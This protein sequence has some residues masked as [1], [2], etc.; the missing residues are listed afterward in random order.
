M[1][2]REVGDKMG[3]RHL[4]RDEI[5]QQCKHIAREKRMANRTPWTAMSIMC[6]YVIMKQ[7]GFKGQ[8]IA[9]ITGR[10]NEMEAQYDNGDID[11]KQISDKLFEKAEWTIEYERYTEKDIKFKKGT[12]EYWFDSIQIEPQ[13]TINE[14]ATRYMLF[15]FIALMEEYGFGK[16]RLT[17]VKEY[18]LNLLSEYQE[19]KECVKNWSKELYEDAG[20]L[21]EMPIDPLT[22]TVGSIMTGY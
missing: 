20:V 7:E 5:I 4:T 13:N 9:K 22:Q 10:V 1:E 8:R 11:L 19:N 17:R 14:Q 12:F 3:R 2:S 16:E 21:V 15:F 18:M 6:S